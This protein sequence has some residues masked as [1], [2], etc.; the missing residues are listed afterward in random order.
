MA[1]WPVS[2][3]IIS[4]LRAS[5]SETREFKVEPIGRSDLSRYLQIILEH[6]DQHTD[7]K[8]P[9]LNVRCGSDRGPPGVCTVS[10]SFWLARKHSDA[11]QGKQERK[12]PLP[13]LSGQDMGSQG[14]PKI[15]RTARREFLDVFSSFANERSSGG[16]EPKG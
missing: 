14:K 3:P 12:R 6:D 2:S 1:N 4:K 7:S 8:K 11:Q 13:I 9:L 15:R 16:T 5:H 10:K